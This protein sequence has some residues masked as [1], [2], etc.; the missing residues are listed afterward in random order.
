M[1]P[2]PGL[3]PAPVNPDDTISEPTPAVEG[4]VVSA[5][6]RSTMAPIEVATAA[7]LE[8]RG[9]TCSQIAEALGRSP[10][11]VRANL[12]RGKDLLKALVPEA[13]E[14]WLQAARV[15]AA[16]GKHTAARDLVYAAGAAAQPQAQQQQIM[17]V[18][19][20]IQ[21]PGLPAPQTASRTDDGPDGE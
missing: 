13:V 16:F 3:P 8:T 11:T 9:L 18:A 17:Q 21:L 4:V 1:L 14:L 6:P 19:I 5:P 15:Q 2:L 10:Q 7:Y 20:G 12:R